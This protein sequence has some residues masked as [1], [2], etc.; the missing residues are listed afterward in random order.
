MESKGLEMKI[1]E[2]DRMVISTL[3][4]VGSL[5]HTLERPINNLFDLVVS[6]VDSSKR[7]KCSSRTSEVDSI[8]CLF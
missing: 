2:H 1:G 5:N 4:F 6:R 8:S 3:D 7:E